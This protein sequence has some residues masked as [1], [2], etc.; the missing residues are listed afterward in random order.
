MSAPE[1]SAATRREG[2]DRLSGE[3]W[4]II[5]VGGGIT[6]AGIAR[7]AVMRGWKTALVEQEDFA[8]GTSS[9]TGRMVHGGFRY[10]ESGQLRLVMESLAE[11]DTLRRTAPGLVA[12]HPFLIPVHGPFLGLAKMAAGVA[13]YQVLALRRAA[14]PA[15][16]AFGKKAHDLEPALR[17]EGLAGGATYWDCLTDDARLVLAVVL[18][19]HRR[20]AVVVNHAPVVGLLWAGGRIA[21]VA[22]R[23][24]PT[25]VTRESRARVV[26]NATGPWLDGVAAMAG[27]RDPALRPTRGAHI[28]V[29]R[30]RLR[31]RR[32][33]IFPSP[34][35]RRYI[36]LLPW[37]RQT[38]IGT[39]EADYEGPPEDV[40]ATRE[41]VAYLL[42][43][44]EGTF[45]EAALR[46]EDILSTFAGVRPLV[47]RPGVA[48][49][50][51]P[52][53]YHIWEEPGGLISVGGGK[54]TTFRRM[55]QETVDLAGRRIRTSAGGQRCLTAGEPIGPLLGPES[56]LPPSWRAGR[57]G[58]DEES[59][60]YFL[61]TYG[62]GAPEVLAQASGN[63]A[64]PLI[65]GLPYL[66]AQVVHAA[67]SEMAIT[68]SDCLV[69]RLHLI[70][71]VPDQ[72]LGCAEEA[73]G[74]MAPQLG[75]GEDEIRAQVEE[76]RREV[77]RTRM[78]RGSG[79]PSAQP[80]RS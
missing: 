43:A 51:V 74:L 73:A 14:G 18:D 17:T 26:V 59:K 47:D 28:V 8:S 58:E 46:V 42:E 7:D 10:L 21:G 23:D 77:A 65:G 53:D 30:D 56:G 27:A 76:Y 25:G 6:G 70:H 64:G 41:D 24:A 9:R 40:C 15:G 49:Y 12:P 4:D 44:A 61:A 39:T 50:R 19:A 11:R 71:E 78:H 45:G 31:T 38:I 72:G 32:A 80:K 33:I 36:Y 79:T 62:M 5:V 54:L 1:C 20:G 68:L 75:W 22:L 48:A 57:A 34:G 52:R 2:L 55:A 16:I 37:G 13:L 60:R 63:L 69:R 29:P 67:R 3:S 66:R 35:D